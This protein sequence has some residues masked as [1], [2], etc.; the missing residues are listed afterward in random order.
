MCAAIAEDK[1]NRVE[2]TCTISGFPRRHTR[3]LQRS[4]MPIA[5][6]NSQSAQHCGWW[7]T[8]ALAPRG[9][10]DS[11][12]GTAAGLVSVMA[13]N[14]APGRAHASCNCVSITSIWIWNRVDR[15]EMAISE[16]CRHRTVSFRSTG[17]TV[18]SCPVAT[19]KTHPQIVHDDEARTLI[20][21]GHGLLADPKPTRKLTPAG[22]YKAIEQLGFV[23]V[24]TIS[25]IQRAHHHILHSR[26]DDYTPDLLTRLLEK[27]RKLFEHWTHDAS[28]IPTVWW[29][30]WQHRFQRYQQRYDS[31]DKW[32]RKQ[33]GDNWTAMVAHVTE[34]IT[35]EGP[36]RSADFEHDRTTSGGWWGWKPQKAALEYL[37]RIGRLSVTARQSFHKVYDLT[38]RVLP[39]LHDCK[40]SE[41]SEHVEWACATALDRLGV[42]TPAE[43]AAFFRAVPI[44]ETRTWAK[45]AVRS[46]RAVAVTVEALDGSKPRSAIAW[47]DWRRR[48]AR[49]PAPPDRMRLLSPFDPVIRDRHRALRL[50]NFDYRFEA[51]VPA[52]KRKY[53]YYV[54][55]I[56]D[57]DRIVGRLDAKTHRDRS[58]LVVNGLWWE[59]DIKP[60]RAR[61]SRLGGA[62]RRLAVGVGAD[63]VVRND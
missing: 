10:V 14:G 3:T 20:L 37:W 33:M 55:P 1:P 45:D 34:R 53:G 28:V 27:Q 19:P 40:Q 11:G 7:H 23:Q 16:K 15:P 58:E 5:L 12:T 62:L 47:H 8:V 46:G 56:L 50:F 61:R 59:P 31:P 25:T 6:S 21:G 49:L 29:P 4:V 2:A 36:L 17:P 51:F 39:V 44:T 52:A 54:L 38:E 18:P 60:T 43:L 35:K 32:L 42:A 22:L 24:D 13:I 41:H 57:C 9:N 48:L 30:H 63:R 26:F